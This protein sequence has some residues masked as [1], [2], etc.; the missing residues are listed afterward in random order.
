MER[1]EIGARIGPDIRAPKPEESQES[2]LG[3]IRSIR[4]LSSE[5]S[6]HQRALAIRSG[7]PRRVGSVVKEYCVLAMQTGRWP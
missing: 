1:I 2:L 6:E 4:N 7:A 5:L 3:I